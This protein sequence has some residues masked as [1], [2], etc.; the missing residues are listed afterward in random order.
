MPYKKKASTE[1]QPILAARR[2]NTLK[3]ADTDQQYALAGLI[4]TCLA[5]GNAVYL[6]PGRFGGVQFK[7]YIEGDQFAEYLEINPALC[8]L[9]E[10]ILD[11]LYD[12]E[13]VAA[14]RNTF[15]VRRAVRPPEPP[16][17]DQ[18]GSATRKEVRARPGGS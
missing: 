5:A 18:Q 15:G 12:K 2:N 14:F 10:E 17:G 16:S 3:E 11:A 1:A 13:A 7:V 8:D 4:V 9:V 6:T